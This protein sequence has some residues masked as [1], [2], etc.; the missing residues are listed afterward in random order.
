MKK[1]ELLETIQFSL[2]G[3]TDTVQS[4]H[5]LRLLEA[6]VEPVYSILVR[7]L[8]LSLRSKKNFSE[9]DQYTKPYIIDVLYDDVR[10]HFYS[11]LPATVI[12]LPPEIA[13]RRCGQTKNEVNLFVP[14]TLGE[15]TQIQRLPV[16]RVVKETYFYMISSDKVYYWNLPVSTGKV[17]MDL[18]VRFREYDDDDE[19]QIPSSFN[20]KNSLIEFIINAMKQFPNAVP[21]LPDER[22][23]E[24]VEKIRK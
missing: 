21:Q 20:E 5:D 14:I 19:I 22:L 24:P 23:N 6:R 2:A 11:E 16:G 8:Y 15:L 17:F 3:G 1:I 9:L 4:R 12:N 13:I 7:D 10:D 18:I